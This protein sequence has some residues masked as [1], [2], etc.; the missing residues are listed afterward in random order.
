[1]QWRQQQ[2]IAA[3]GE[4]PRVI[5]REAGAEGTPGDGGDEEGTPAGGGPLDSAL[6]SL[7]GMPAERPVDVRERTTGILERDRGELWDAHD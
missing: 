7:L 5:I 1:M 2:R 6:R 3:G 4:R